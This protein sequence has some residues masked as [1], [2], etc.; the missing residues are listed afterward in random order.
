ML[1]RFYTSFDAQVLFC[2]LVPCAPCLSG[3]RMSSPEQSAPL[4]PLQTYDELLADT[5]EL[6]DTSEPSR[7]FT[8]QGTPPCLS[9]FQYVQD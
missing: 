4:V 5:F 9:Q 7:N 1:D 8:K 3:F 2:L 6:V